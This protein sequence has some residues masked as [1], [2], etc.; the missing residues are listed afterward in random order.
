MRRRSSARRIDTPPK[1]AAGA[2]S[3]EWIAAIAV[4][5]AAAM[6]AAQFFTSNGVL[7]RDEVG[8]VNT[9]SAPTIAEMWRLHEFDSF[10]LLW[11]LMLRGWLMAGGTSDVSLRLFGM[12][13]IAAWVVAAWLVARRIGRGVPLVGLA[14]VVVNPEVVRWASTVRPWGLGAALG[15]IAAVAM[16]DL[17]TVRSRRTVIVAAL[18]AV[19]AVQC[20]YQ[21]AIVLAAC[22]LASGVVALRRRQWPCVLVPLAI[23]AAAA[24]SLAPYAGIMSRRAEWNH[25]GQIPLTVSMLL[26]QAGGVLGA[27]GS[28]A[29]LV[30][31]ALA[32]V[33]LALVGRQLRHDSGVYFATLVAAATAGFGVFYLWFRY[34]PQPWYF[35]GAMAMWSVGLEAAVRTLAPARSL[36][37]VLAIGALGIVMAGYRPASEALGQRLTNLDAI[38][39]RVTSMAGPDDL[40]V[41][42]PWYFCVTFDRYYRGRAPVSSVPPLADHTMH[43]YDLVKAQM[44]AADPMA[45]LLARVQRVLSSGHHVW[46]VGRIDVPADGHLP[47]L[48]PPPRPESGWSVVPYQK[49]WSLQLGSF[50]RDHVGVGPRIPIGVTGG[51]LE[52][53]A[54][55]DLSGWRD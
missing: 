12:I 16:W 50:L 7:W 37:V 36:R 51:R 55:Y 52:D 8:S 40:V 28:W 26:Q 32:M 34:F 11:A 48:L 27:S 29:L 4:T 22:V 6:L 44:M 47:A 1:P 49:I 42:S 38:A 24:V 14:L 46:Y 54:L 17:T 10:P 43:R 30:W 41:V 13:G 19:V 45:A 2:T 25:L 31:L 5:V 33:A 53:A 3:L 21:N 9:Q 20:V 18:A 23:V 15:A 35:F 39:A